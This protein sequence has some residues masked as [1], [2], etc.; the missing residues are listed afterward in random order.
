MS[1]PV[2]TPYVNRASGAALAFGTVIVLLVAL[3]LGARF[4]VAT[5][6]ID[7]ARAAARYQALAEIHTNE[8][9]ALNTAA[10]L[11]QDH[12]VVRLPVSLAIQLTAQQWQHPEQARADLIARAA[13]AAA[14]LPKVAPKPSAF[15]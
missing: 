9:A 7:A 4:L 15:E 1:N 13:K 10:W 5:P 8:D 3:T 6:P 2:P 14:P 11:D 12:G